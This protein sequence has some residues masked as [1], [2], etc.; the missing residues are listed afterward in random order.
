MKPLDRNR[1]VETGFVSFH[2][3]VDEDGN[4][5]PAATQTRRF[6]QLKTTKTLRAISMLATVGAAIVGFVG[7]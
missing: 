4:T 2:A 7:F 3:S 6:G 5:Y 1:L